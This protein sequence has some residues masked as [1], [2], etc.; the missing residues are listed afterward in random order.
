[1][2]RQHRPDPPHQATSHFASAAEAAV[3][4]RQAVARKGG[5][6]VSIREFASKSQPP[7]E[8]SAAVHLAAALQVS[9]DVAP[10]CYHLGE[11]FLL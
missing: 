7:D 2:R 11:L 6:A 8:S 5:I 1:M 9:P 3:V 10:L 4:V